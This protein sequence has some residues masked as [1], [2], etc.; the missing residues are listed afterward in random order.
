MSEVLELPNEE[1]LQ[2][3]DEGLQFY[4]SQVHSQVNDNIEHL[5]NASE[6]VDMTSVSIDRL[7]NERKELLDKIMAEVDAEFPRLNELKKLIANLEAIKLE[8][9]SKGKKLEAKSRKI[10]LD[11]IKKIPDADFEFTNGVFSTAV[12]RNKEKHWDEKAALEFATERVLRHVPE[13][14]REIVEFQLNT[15]FT[16]DKKKIKQAKIKGVNVPDEVMRLEDTRGV[17]YYKGKL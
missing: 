6:S 15:F 3:I 14:Y 8:H 10:I 2:S 1:Q 9:Q 16:L 12:T 4:M 7:E 13:Q 17:K 5:K 11:A